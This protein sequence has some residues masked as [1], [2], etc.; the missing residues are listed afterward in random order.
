[1]R[2]DCKKLARTDIAQMVRSI[3]KG[4]CYDVGGRLKVKW[5]AFQ[6]ECC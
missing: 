2:N 6:K 4:D 1:M 3:Q 5:D